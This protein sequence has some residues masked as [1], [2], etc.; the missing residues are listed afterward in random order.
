MSDSFGG[1]SRRELLGGAGLGL[2]GMALGQPRIAAA[3][4][5]WHGF[6][7]AILI[8]ALGILSNPNAWV[9][10]AGQGGDRLMLSYE[11]LR[12]VDARVLADARASGTTAVNI[13][14][15]YA[16]GP[17]EP[18]EFTVTDIARWNR[19]IERN[20]TDLIH[21]TTAADI[22][23]AKRDGVVGV[24]Y[25]FQNAAMMGNDAERVETFA[26]LGVRVIQ[27]T[28]NNRNQI[29]DGS[30]ESENRGLTDFGHEVIE[31]LNASRVL[32]DL[33]HSGE[34]TCL[35]ALQASREPICISHTGCRALNDLPRNKTDE[36]L[37]L[38][39]DSGGVVGIYFMPFLKADGYPDPEDI[40]LHLE[41]A[42][43]VCGEDHVGIGTDG[44]TT[45]V[46]DLEAYRDVTRREL[47]ERRAAGI[48]A[49]G[50]DPGIVPFVP[51][52]QGPDQFRQLADMLYRRGHSSARIEKILGGNFLRLFEAVWGG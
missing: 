23:R 50:E 41:Q 5:A 20:P 21:V 44:G 33:S 31:H 24:I 39:A 11:R 12:M 19:I 35:D 48:A 40:V 42:V 49:P 30:A 15:G 4:D 43:N 22:R 7:D 1:F 27:L 3:Q 8:N 14:L 26:G 6:E 13:T 18:Y 37:R 2:A 17:L 9:E 38:V 52:L 10:A 34:Q 46:D 29:G 16:A 28:Y 36:E 25:G 51:D 47:E 32:I 45:A